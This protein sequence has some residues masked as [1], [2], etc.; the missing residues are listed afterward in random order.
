MTDSEKK[1][2]P[3][4]APVAVVMISL[5]EAHNL[6]GV[7]NNL[8]G[9]AQ[10]VHLV[11]SCSTD[12]TI[13]IALRYGVNVVQ[14]KFKGFGDQWN[15]AINSSPIKAPFT[16]KLDPDE[17]LSDEL[18]AEILDLILKK[19]ENSAFL[20]PIRLFFMGTRLPSVLILT[21]LW[22]TG[23]VHFSNVEAN[24]HALTDGSVGV[25]NKEIEHHDSPS[26]DHWVTKQNRYT[27]TEAISQFQGQK[28]SVSP[29]L[30]GGKLARRM[31]LKKYFWKFPGRFVLL[32]LYHYFYIGAWKSGKVGWIWSH[33]RTEVYR[34]WEYKFFEI[35]RTGR[36][37]T[38]IPS[39]AGSPDPRVKFYE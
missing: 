11:D 19:P 35:N 2:T 13:D 6:E 39:H 36:L 33:L 24:E 25:L 4:V 26:L 18:K 3:G 21:R 9:W 5:N 23:A 12:Q 38:Q 14:R 30:F 28:F 29:S 16:M 15:F 31:W 10:E 37:P 17:R 22:K 20:V 1:W 8:K 7:L 32:F 27:T 34:M